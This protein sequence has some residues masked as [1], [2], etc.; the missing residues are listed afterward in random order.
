M[1]LD[2]GSCTL[3]PWRSGDRDTLATL[4]DDRRIWRNMTDIFPHP[5][6]IDDAE[7]WIT[8]CSREGDPPF[9]FTI[10]VDSAPVGGIGAHLLSGEQRHVANVGYWLTPGVWGRG[11]ATDALRRFTRYLFDTFDVSRLYATVFGWNPAS[12]RVLEKCGY[13]LEGRRRDAIVKQGRVT[14]LL[15]YGLLQSD[16]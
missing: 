9:S 12:A 14:D 1:E 8:K 6:T 13:R 5:Y 4:A 2:A 16:L 15:E 11:I 7:D 3:R 10:V